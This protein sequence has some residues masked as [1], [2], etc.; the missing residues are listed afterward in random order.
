[1]SDD[2]KEIQYYP[3]ICRIL[4]KYLSDYLPNGAKIE[5]SMNKQ[6]PDM[7]RDI[8]NSIE[9]KTD[10]R[11]GFIPKLK[12]DI[13]IGIKHSGCDST[14]LCLVEVKR[15]K[16]LKLMD[17]SQ[18]AGYLQVARQIK[19]GILLLVSQSPSQN[20]LSND[21]NEILVMRQLPADWDM[22]V[23][24]FKKHEKFGF[25]TGICIYTVNNGLDWVQS[26]DCGGIS[27]WEALIDHIISDQCA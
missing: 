14:H 10:F 26:N 21:F 5:F 8:E 24:Y 1:M 17:F 13:L 6:L 12:L 4:N 16:S 18:L 2:T 9:A 19:T 22:Y 11:D 7:V 27:N 25:R 15:S 20:S 23:K 3:A